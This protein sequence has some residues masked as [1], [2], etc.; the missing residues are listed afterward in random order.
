MQGKK[1]QDTKKNKKHFD[2]SE[3]EKFRPLGGS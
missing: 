3:F 1:G 2:M